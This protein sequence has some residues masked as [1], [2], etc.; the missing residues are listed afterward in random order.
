MLSKEGLAK[1]IS[2][3]DLRGNETAR[4]FFGVDGK[5]ALGANGLAGYRQAFDERGNVV[6]ISYLGVDG[7]ATLSKQGIAAV[8]YAYDGHGNEVQR[9]FLGLDG[10]PTFGPDGYAGTAARKPRRPISALVAGQRSVP[11]VSPERLMSMTRGAMRSSGPFLASTASR[12]SASWDLL[13]PGRPSTSV[14]I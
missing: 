13:V 4:A 2:T 14:A 9:T 12:P 3:Y 7:R 8:S 10:T 5:P 6:K 1:T 11:T